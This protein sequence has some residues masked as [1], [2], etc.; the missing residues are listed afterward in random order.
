MPHRPRLPALLALAALSA[1]AAHAQAYPQVRGP[2]GTSVA[3]QPVTNVGVLADGV[4]PCVAAA[5]GC[6]PA[7]SAA[8]GL[9]PLTGTFTTPGPSAS[10]T[11]IAGRGFDIVISGAFSGSIQ[12]ERQLNGVWQPLTVSAGGAITQLYLYAADASDIAVEPQ[13]GVP[14][15]LNCTTLTSGTPSYSVSQ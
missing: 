5:A 10:F 3:P 4:T 7:S 6:Q 1:G 13:A 12:L 2:G 14:Y 9:T 15:R 11:P 8:S